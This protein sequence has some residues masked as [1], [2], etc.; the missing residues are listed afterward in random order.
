MTTAE[1][2]QRPEFARLIIA[3]RIGLCSRILAALG[4][5]MML[6][7]PYRDHVPG[8]ALVAF[9]AALALSWI[10]QLWSMRGSRAALRSLHDDFDEADLRDAN[11]L[12]VRIARIGE[13]A[14]R[15][16]V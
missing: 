2:E 7:L 5:V 4:L 11:R 12:A 13:R 1:I 16:A 10:G 8:R 15:R 14:R 3:H 9:V 6:A